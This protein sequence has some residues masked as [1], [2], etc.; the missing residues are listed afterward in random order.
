[1]G[2]I[3]PIFAISVF[4]ILKQKTN[5]LI[6]GTVLLS[7]FLVF[8]NFILLSEC[9]LIQYLAGLINLFSIL[10]F[11]IVT[12]NPFNQFTYTKISNK[13]FKLIKIFFYGNIFFRYF[14]LLLQELCY[15]L[16]ISFGLISLWIRNL[17][18]FDIPSTTAVASLSLLCVISK[19]RIARGLIDTKKFNFTFFYFLPT[20][21][22]TFLAGSGTSIIGLFIFTYY[23]R[24]IVILDPFPKFHFEKI[25]RSS[26]II[27]L[28]L[29]GFPLITILYFYLHLS[30]EE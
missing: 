23:A 4:F 18:F 16:K 20:V 3:F 10:S 9:C 15:S 28:L 6:L 12:L 19:D 29:I 24:D 22:S 21:I 30:W 2:R 17:G 5:Y 8:S 25:F 13:L 14:N 11:L 7:L 27:N 1:M 26:F